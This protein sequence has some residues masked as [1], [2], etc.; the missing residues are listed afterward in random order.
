[1]ERVKRESPLDFEAA[2]FYVRS[3]MLQAGAGALEQVLRE[4]GRGR[5]REP[6]VCANKHL[7]CAMQSIG[8]RS[9]TLTSI[10]GEVRFERSAY[11]C[12]RCGAT[13]Y[14]GDEALG[15]RATGFSPG[16]RRMMA[17]A[18]SEMSGF[19]AAAK[20]LE[21]YAAMRVGH[22]DVE[23]VAEATGRAAEG[24]MARAGTAALA[25]P[26]AGE[27]P[28]VCYISFD[29]TGAPVRAEELRGVKGKGADGRART[30]EVKLGCVFTQ[31][32]LDEEGRPVR[33]EGST[34]YV[35]AIEPSVDFGYR[36]YAEAVRRGM[37]NARRAVIIVD[38]AAYNKSIIA[39]H[40][41][42]DATVIIDL[43][44]AREHL[45][46]FVRDALL[47]KIEGPV[48]GALGALLDAGAIEQLAERMRE[49][50]PANGPRR[51]EGKK[52]IA[53]FLSNASHMRYEQYRKEGLFVGSG[54]IEAGCRVVVGSRLKQSGMFWSVP[55][56]NSIIAL[57]CCIISGRFEQFWEDQAA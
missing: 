17:R 18:G 2:E 55:G 20:A 40:F 9:K 53:Y 47:Q 23:R 21:L 54:V 19:R 28:D 45:D 1:M 38:G 42:A 11:R 5:R 26:P 13:R 16:A 32:A 4:V 43:Y 41:P 7:P 14:P 27:K 52:Q 22:K 36:L 51:A 6:L 30:R 37:L 34:T 50:L 33:E 15:V 48:H 44:H 56:A 25:A 57:R 31:S 49:L 8:L 29:G 46:A 12:P 24:W 10:L 35:G 39:A 3:A